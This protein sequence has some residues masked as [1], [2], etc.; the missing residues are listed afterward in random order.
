MK[1][2]A[3]I[4]GLTPIL[5]WLGAAHS[6]NKDGGPSSTRFQSTFGLIIVLTTFMIVW[7]IVSL[8]SKPMTLAPIPESVSIPF[9]TY[10][11]MFFGAKAISKGQEVNA[12]K[13]DD[14]QKPEDKP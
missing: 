2:L 10:L 4:L 1:T 14:S 9:G 12:A 3:N 11:A 7:A 5:E 13:K 8:T 6:E